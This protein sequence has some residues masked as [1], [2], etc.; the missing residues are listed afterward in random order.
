MIFPPPTGP[1]PVSPAPP[2]RPLLHAEVLANGLALRFYAAG[3]RYF[4][5][6]H[7]VAIAMETILPLDHPAL[8]ALDPPLLAR[9]QARFGTVLRV[10]KELVRMGVESARVATVQQELIASALLEAQRYLARP[11]Y[12]ARLLRAELERKAVLKPLPR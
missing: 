9:A 3:N 11:D 1:A 5:D 12:P 10:V 4:G 8:T 7:R 2:E 6:Y